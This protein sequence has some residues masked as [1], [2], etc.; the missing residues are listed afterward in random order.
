M[1]FSLVRDD[2]EERWVPCNLCGSF[3]LSR[4]FT[5]T[6]SAKQVVRCRRCG[7]VFYDPQP[8]PRRA[9]ALYSPGYFDRE[10]PEDQAADQIQL[11]QRRLTRIESEVGVG[12]LLDVGCGVGRFLLVARQRGW[13]TVGLDV[14]PA[15]VQKAAATSGAT[16][17]Q[18]D[19]SR[20]RPA[21]MVPF[22]VVTMWDV[23][24]HLSDPVGYLRRVHHWTR[25]GGMVVIQ[26]Q[27]ANSVTAAWMRQRW[28]QFV[29]FH[30]FHFSTQTLQLALEAAGF[31]QIRIEASEEFSRNAL[32]NPGQPPTATPGFGRGLRDC[33]RHLRDFA[34]ICCGYDSY[35]IMVATGR[36]PHGE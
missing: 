14:A 6:Q 25:S 22:D 7:L 10:F 34:F 20:A 23:F 17:L 1:G 32:S 4:L 30:L 36:C 2:P 18:G 29:E 12:R 31:E 9:V 24:E 35:N 26:T 8:L 27:N 15:A 11:A 21:G 28:E 16:V 13:E 33:L 19:L 5:A 3:D